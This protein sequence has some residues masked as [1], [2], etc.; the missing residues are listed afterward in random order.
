MNLNMYFNAIFDGV[1]AGQ[2]GFTNSIPNIAQTFFPPQDTGFPFGDAVPWIIAIL[3]VLFAFPLLLGETAALIGVGAGALLIGS[4]TTA[5]DQLEPLPATNILSVVEMQNYAGKYGETT[6]NAIEGWANST[7]QGEKDSAG[8][9]VLNYIAGGAFVDA[10][11]IPKAQEIE[12]FWKS[13]EHT[14]DPFLDGGVLTVI[15][16]RDGVEDD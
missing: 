1:V 9:S 3:T 12:G 15:L 6:R 8:G 7:F 13:R 16:Y 5:N 4:T 2:L 10:K 11:V 14:A